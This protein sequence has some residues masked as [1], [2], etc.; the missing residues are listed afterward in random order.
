MR[1][2]NMARFEEEK[3]EAWWQAIDRCPGYSS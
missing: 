1:K 2:R 3:E